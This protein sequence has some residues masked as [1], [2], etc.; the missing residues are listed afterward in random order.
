MIKNGSTNNNKDGRQLP[1]LIIPGFMS[2]GLTIQKSPHKSWEGKRLW[3]NVR[4]AGF[5]SLHVGGALEKNEQRRSVRDITVSFDQS[6]EEMHQEYAKQMECKSKWVWH[7]RLQRDMIHEKEG[8]AVRPIPGTA[9][10]DYLAPGALTEGASYVFGPV[11]KL[12]K[13]K[14]YIEGVNMDAAPYD[15]RIPVSDCI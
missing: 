15:W 10:V 14:G 8:V 6:S 5:N 9:G 1:V 2:S 13:A 12:L 3:L 11:L 4:A 7:M